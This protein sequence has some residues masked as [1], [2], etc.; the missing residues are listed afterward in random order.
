MYVT[1][2]TPTQSNQ[3]NQKKPEGY[4]SSQQAVAA[5]VLTALNF[6]VEV[7]VTVTVV[8]A[9]TVLVMVVVGAVTVASTMPTKVV[10]GGAVML[11]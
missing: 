4:P 8:V 11:M 9:S 1:Q 7:C 2:C 3:S 6:M 10:T 5:A